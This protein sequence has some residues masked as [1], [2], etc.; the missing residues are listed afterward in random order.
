MIGWA[1]VS[2]Q[3]NR[4]EVRKEQRAVVDAAKKLAVECAA[5]SS[6]YMCS[7]GRDEAAEG[8][9]KSQ[10]DLLEIELGRIPEYGEDRALVGAMAKFADACTGADFESSSKAAR[11]R[12]DAEVLLISSTR[13]ALLKALEENFS[14]RYSS[15]S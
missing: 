2:W 11:S 15:A 4:R 13:N 12:S 5:A 1:I 8:S 7:E 14:R 6:T 9:I 10:L 3:A